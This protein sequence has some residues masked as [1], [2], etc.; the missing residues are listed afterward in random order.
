MW[1]NKIKGMATPCYEEEERLQ[2]G[3]RSVVSQPG[4][5]DHH[6]DLGL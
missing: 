3:L 1:E 2:V 6:E 4:Q 5:G